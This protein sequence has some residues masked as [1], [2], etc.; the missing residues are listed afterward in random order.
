MKN[1]IQLVS[2]IIILIVLLFLT[3]GCSNKE[4]NNQGENN[5]DKNVVQEDAKL[6]PELNGVVSFAEK[7]DGENSSKIVALKSDGTEISITQSDPNEYDAIDY[8]GG[9]LYLK[10]NNYFFE[11]DLTKG[12]GNYEVTKLFGFGYPLNQTYSTDSGDYGYIYAYNGK[13]YFVKDSEEIIEYDLSTK[14]VNELVKDVEF[15]DIRLDKENGVMYYVQRNPKYSLNSY[16]ISTGETKE[17][18]IGVSRE[19]Q[20]S[21]RGT[22]LPIGF[23]GL[24]INEGKVLY[25]KGI[26]EADGASAYEYYLYDVKTGEKQ[27]VEKM[28]DGIYA[29]GKIYYSASDEEVVAYPPHNLR[30][31]EN[32]NVTEL[33]ELQ[34]NSYTRFYDLGNGKIQAVMQWG[35][36]ISTAGEQAY[37]IDKATNEVT[38]AS[39]NYTLV[40]VIQE[41]ENVPKVE[42]QEKEVENRI[43]VEQATEIIKNKWGIEPNNDDETTS[44]AGNYVLQ[45]GAQ[46][47]TIRDVDGLEYYVF[48]YSSKVGESGG[49]Y[50]NTHIQTIFISVDGKKYKIRS[51]GDNFGDKDIVTE[52]DEEGEL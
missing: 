29:D 26:F 19:N 6:N 7:I 44:E 36:D 39:S 47:F 2:S 46:D 45:G 31:Y 22:N 35:Q 16:N 20:Y 12:D 50:H 5:Q 24:G 18:E 37:L 21:S 9:I 49:T 33:T 38:K 8:Y 51:L 11:V 3:T 30:V 52:F 14:K 40:H 34:E 23:Q 1:K 43:T 15:V 13:I 4:E 42:Y 48:S 10:R 28:D 27:K 17:I 25:T 32:G 41:T